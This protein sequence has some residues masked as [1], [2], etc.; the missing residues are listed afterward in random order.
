MSEGTIGEIAAILKKCTIHAIAKRKEFIDLG[1]L[2]EI[3]YIAPSQ[4]Q[5]KYESWMI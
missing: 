5:R 4:R 2:A 3:Q 1:V